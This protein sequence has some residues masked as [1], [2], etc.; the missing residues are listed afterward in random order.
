MLIVYTVAPLLLVIHPS[1][2]AVPIYAV[3]NISLMVAGR[4]LRNR[5]IK[6]EYELQFSEN[7][8][9]RNPIRRTLTESTRLPS[10]V[11]SSSI[12]SRHSV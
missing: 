2:I 5:R 6:L 8:Y 3:I 11:S 7:F 1:I 12:A 9:I 4:V 10:G